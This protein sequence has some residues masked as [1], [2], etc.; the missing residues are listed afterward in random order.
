MEWFEMLEGAP[1]TV[2]GNA[3]VQASGRMDVASKK[4]S[5]STS[6]GRCKIRSPFN[7]ASGDHLRFLRPEALACLCDAML[8]R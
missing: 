8:R 3:V 5:H 6:R 7:A 1:N 4:N 2:F